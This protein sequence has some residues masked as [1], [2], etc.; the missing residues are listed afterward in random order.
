MQT[1]FKTVRIC[2][3]M[4]LALVSGCASQTFSKEGM[5]EQTYKRD[6]FE[7]NKDSLAMSYASEG[8][9]RRKYMRE[10][11]EAKGYTAN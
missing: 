1:G 4:L 7:C 9:G 5:T 2:G 8:F 3:L 10:C 11:M 6:H